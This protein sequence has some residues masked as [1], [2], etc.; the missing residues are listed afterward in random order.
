MTNGTPPQN[1]KPEVEATRWSPEPEKILRIH[2]LLLAEYGDH[3]WHPRDP[4]ATLVSTILSQNTN[5]V[6]RDRAFE[7]LRE[8][9]PTWEA[10][11]DAPL[12]D[13]IEAIRP[14]GLAPTKAPRIQEVLRRITDEE[15]RIS[16]DFL[17]GMPSE[18][19]R[20]WLLSLP[21][22]GPKT[23]A[24]V[25]CFALG[26]PA[27]PVDTHIHRVARRLGWIPQ[28]TSRERAHE[29]LEA[30]IPPQVY[31]PLHL[32]LIAHGR[33]VC[34][35]HAP[36]CEACVLRN[37]CAF[38]ASKNQPSTSLQLILIRH[39][40]T[41][42]NVERRWVGWGDTEIT[43]RGH[44]Q[45]E[46]TARRLVA[47]VCGEAAIYTSPLPRARKTAEAI[48][49]ALGLEPIPVEGLREIHFGDLD[50][51]TLKEMQT[52]YPDLY[53]RWLDKDDAEYT[54]PG[55]EKRADFFRRVAGACTEIL[56]RHPQGTV[57]I[58]AHGGT[59]R[60]C[61]AYLLP[62]ELGEW[63]AYPLDHC[64]LTRV[65]V[66]KGQ[67]RLLALNETDHLPAVSGDR[68]P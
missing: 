41:A 10:A 34:Q 57:I 5:D 28:R 67:A 7:Q 18:A 35:A 8:R 63:W 65:A 64:G 11:R 13:L 27:F 44:A 29:L 49:R 47:E 20:S 15:G 60:A 6:N 4:V 62:E 22:V 21:G 53:A 33:A 36:R 42:A 1:L 19:A 31:Y 38:F 23:A 3:P 2:N 17:A 30:I 54:W 32:N 52:R 66:T 37:E 16:L 25:L 56:S 46:A 45:I 61:L 43:E 12:P 55:G 59:L 9:F 39:A 58:V 51:V 40:E 14:A 24:I 68:A 50:G 26:R 48:G